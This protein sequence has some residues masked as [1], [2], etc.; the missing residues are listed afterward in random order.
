MF[1][2]WVSALDCSAMLRISSFLLPSLEQRFLAQLHHLHPPA[3]ESAKCAMTEAF[4][5]GRFERPGLP[6]TTG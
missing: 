3:I 4:A 1:Y 6:A 2:R 5:W